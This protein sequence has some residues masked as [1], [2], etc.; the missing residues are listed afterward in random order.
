MNHDAPVGGGVRA[1]GP[2]DVLHTELLRV[3]WISHNG[4][5]LQQSK[6]G[7]FKSAGVT[8]Q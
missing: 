5:D 3:L 7:Q 6:R 2:F 4:K 8:V 1:N